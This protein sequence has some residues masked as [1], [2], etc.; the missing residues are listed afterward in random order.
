MTTEQPKRVDAGFETMD[1]PQE[2]PSDIEEPSGEVEAP[3]EEES[4]E[5]DEKEE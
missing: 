2:E 4:P 1:L 5:P 3:E